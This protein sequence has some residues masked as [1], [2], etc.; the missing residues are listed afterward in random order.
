MRVRRKGGGCPRWALTS[1]TSAP[2][3]A[4]RTRC[5]R[6]CGGAGSRS[7]RRRGT[8]S[9]DSETAQGGGRGKPGV[10]GGGGQVEMRAGGQAPVAPQGVRGRRMSAVELRRRQS[11][12]PVQSQSTAT[13]A[14]R[15]M[16]AS[17]WEDRGLLHHWKVS[18]GGGVGGGTAKQ[19]ERERK[20]IWEGK[21]RPKRPDPSEQ[22][23]RP[24]GLSRTSRRAQPVLVEAKEEGGQEQGQGEGVGE[25]AGD[26]GRG[27]EGPGSV[28][29]GVA[30]V[31]GC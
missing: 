8:T 12:P 16:V 24:T 18:K 1:T 6:W 31:E 4:G 19:L 10:G 7:G 29:G 2:S 27:E 9:A 26:G 15:A 11:L 3:M 14:S 28:Q 20:E 23:S 22:R 17:A 25:G 21:V 30:P 13:L 5:G